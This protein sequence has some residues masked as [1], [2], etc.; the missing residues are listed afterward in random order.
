MLRSNLYDLKD[1]FREIIEQNTN[2][3]IFPIVE[4]PNLTSCEKKEKL[5]EDFLIKSIKIVP[6]FPPPTKDIPTDLLK[7]DKS[8]NDII[9]IGNTNPEIIEKIVEKG[10]EI[11]LIKDSQKLTQ[12]LKEKDEVTADNVL[13]TIPLSNQQNIVLNGDGTNLQFELKNQANVKLLTTTTTIININVNNGGNE[14]ESVLYLNSSSNINLGGQ[15]NLE[16]NSDSN[17]NLR[18]L[19][20]NNQ[21]MNLKSSNDIEFDELES[22]QN[23]LFS[24]DKTIRFHHL[25]IKQRSELAIFNSTILETIHL[26]PFSTLK[27]NNADIENAEVTITLSPN[28]LQDI[29]FYG[30][31]SNPPKSIRMQASNNLKILSDDSEKLIKFAISDNQFDQCEQWISKIDFGNSGYYSAKGSEYNA[32]Q[33]RTLLLSSSGQKPNPTGGAIAAIAICVLLIVGVAI[34]LVLYFFV[35][36]KKSKA[37]SQQ[38]M[39]SL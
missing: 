15:G 36:K 27:I 12:T 1:Y 8:F 33:G 20:L 4:N 10:E 23:S 25:T 13:F 35:F 7:I 38:L 9:S 39:L 32:D 26:M 17:L 21:Q 24:T 34:G 6:F 16:I 5:S 29:S 28:R 30:N 22:Y 31:L 14:E 18:K 2:Q 11:L 37:N 3:I 19:V